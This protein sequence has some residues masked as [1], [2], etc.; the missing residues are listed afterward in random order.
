[1]RKSESVKLTTFQKT[2]IGCVLG[3]IALGA[4]VG[5]RLVHA[6]N[7]AAN[8]TEDIRGMAHSAKDAVAPLGQKAIEK[9]KEAL[10]HVD[11]KELGEKLTAG[12]KEVG[13]EVKEAAIDATRKAKEK[14]AEK[15]KKKSDPKDPPPS[16]EEKSPD[17]SGAG[18]G[19]NG[20][21]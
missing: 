5:W 19:K 2:M 21:R 7:T 3:A 16:P 15:L 4:V 18:D 17:G 20:G 8:A 11:S 1:M 12:T 14:L 9:G 6:A 13:R 10:D